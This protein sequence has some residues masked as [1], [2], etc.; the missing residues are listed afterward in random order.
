MLKVN[1]ARSFVSVFGLF[2]CL[3]V[4]LFLKRGGGGGRLISVWRDREHKGWRWCVVE[5]GGGGG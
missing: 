4:L 3:F 5:L 2:V 1:N